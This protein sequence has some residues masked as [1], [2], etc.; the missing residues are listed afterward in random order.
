LLRDAGFEIAE[1]GAVGVKD[2]CFALGRIP[3]AA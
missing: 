2:L 1:S 3:H